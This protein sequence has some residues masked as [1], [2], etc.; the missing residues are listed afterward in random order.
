M[1]VVDSVWRYTELGYARVLDRR[2]EYRR[3]A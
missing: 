1:L 2:G 3:P